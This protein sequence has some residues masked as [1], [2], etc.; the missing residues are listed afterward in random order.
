MTGGVLLASFEFDE[1]GTRERIR[2]G[3]AFDYDTY[4]ILLHHLMKPHPFSRIREIS[5]QEMECILAG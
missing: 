4:K 3:F 1:H 2:S 5:R